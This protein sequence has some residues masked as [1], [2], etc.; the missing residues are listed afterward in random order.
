M[1]F[2][3]FFTTLVHK[4]Q[5]YLWMFSDV[6][7]VGCLICHSRVR[8][9]PIASPMKA[10][11]SV[12]QDFQQLRSEH[13]NIFAIKTNNANSAKNMHMNLETVTPRWSVP[14]P[15]PH[16]P[17]RLIKMYLNSKGLPASSWVLRA[18][19]RVRKNKS[20]LRAI[21]EK[22]LR[23]LVAKLLEGRSQSGAS[24]FISKWVLS[25][26]SY[27]LQYKKYYRSA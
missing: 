19:E 16:I 6:G 10:P 12:F 20:K 17:T 21:C 26:A 24:F 25:F 9:P 3:G 5:K 18:A 1:A 22:F 2:Y 11:P 13:E 27:Q 23:V 7:W 4:W 8:A 14:H 15:S